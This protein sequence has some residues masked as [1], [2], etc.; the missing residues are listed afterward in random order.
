MNALEIHAAI[1]RLSPGIPTT[2]SLTDDGVLTITMADGTSLSQAD[3]EADM[4]ANGGFIDLRIER[5]LK[6]MA[7]DWTQNADVVLSNQ[8]AWDAYRQALRDLPANTIDP[9]SPAWPVRP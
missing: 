6:L 4:T 7:T 8:V 1:E 9:E 2:F 5:D 3:V